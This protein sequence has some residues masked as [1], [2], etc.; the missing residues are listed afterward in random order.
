MEHRLIFAGFGGQGV[1]FAGKLLAHAGML[2]DKYVTWIPSYG[3]EMRGGTANCA[4]VISD[5]RIGSPVV[6][7]PDL[8][9]V[10]NKASFDKFHP[11]VKSGG[12][13]IIN[14]SIVKDEKYRD[15]INVIEVPANDLAE[16]CGSIK[17]ANMIIVGSVNAGLNL[18]P[19][20]KI[21]EALEDEVGNK[22]P[23]LLPVNKD[24]VKM[25]MKLAE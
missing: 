7:K 3:P 11:K 21:F 16:E 15:D 10:M 5:K 19:I 25:G 23:E 6:D 9:V 4:V 2:D 1:L 14:T 8:A 13:L 22:R 17:V 12:S 18:L 20:E 24:A